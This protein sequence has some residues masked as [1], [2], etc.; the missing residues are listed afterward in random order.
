MRLYCSDGSWAGDRRGEARTGKKLLAAILEKE[1]P[2]RRVPRSSV[3]SQSRPTGRLAS[4]E[5]HLRTAILDPNARER[6]VADTLRR[7]CGDRAAAVRK[8]L[9]DLAAEDKRWS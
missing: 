7:T 8:V 5:G 9:S 1:S 2:S 3:P 6:L 4:L